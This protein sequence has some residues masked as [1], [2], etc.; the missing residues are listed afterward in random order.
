[1]T[2]SYEKMKEKLLSD[3]I[4]TSDRDSNE[5]VFRKRALTRPRV[6]RI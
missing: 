6:R 5:S 2:S 3:A 4:P 1:M